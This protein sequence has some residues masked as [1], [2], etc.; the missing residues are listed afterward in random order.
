MQVL[1]QEV[2][3]VGAEQLYFSQAPRARGP[4]LEE[5]DFHR[6][7]QSWLLKFPVPG[8]QTS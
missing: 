6:G 2:A 5:T 3:G 8:M 4:H 1:T 7:S